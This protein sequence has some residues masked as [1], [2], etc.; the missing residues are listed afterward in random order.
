MVMPMMVMKGNMMMSD[1][2]KAARQLEQQPADEPVAQINKDPGTHTQYV[3]WMMPWSLFP[4]G[5]LFYT[6]PRPAAPWVGLT[7]D[8][9]INVA[10]SID[11]EFKDEG[12]A[13]QVDDILT[14]ARAIEAML[15]EKNFGNLSTT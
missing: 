5:T 13:E 3:Q 14:F 11:I 10:K 7:D 6:R 4:D 12:L 8:Q 2:E 15:K 9:I 1:L